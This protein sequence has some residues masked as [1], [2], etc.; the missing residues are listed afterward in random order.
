MEYGYYGWNIDIMGGIWISWVEYRYHGWN[1]DIMG[2][3]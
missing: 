3:I 1:M 2:G